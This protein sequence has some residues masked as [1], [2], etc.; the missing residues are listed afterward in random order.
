MRDCPGVPNYCGKSG[1]QLFFYQIWNLE[2]EIFCYVATREELTAKSSQEFMSFVHNE[3]R[4]TK[5]SWLL[6]IEPKQCPKRNQRAFLYE[7]AEIL[8]SFV[9]CWIRGGSR[10]WVGASGKLE[11]S[12]T[13]NANKRAVTMKRMKKRE[14]PMNLL[15]KKNLRIGLIYFGY[16]I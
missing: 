5:D 7:I 4:I 1:S 8:L 13:V 3:V 14:W 6:S 16:C 2:V 11:S 9:E 15:R 10:L 12:K